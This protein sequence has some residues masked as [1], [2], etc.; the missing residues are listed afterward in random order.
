MLAANRNIAAFGDPV[1]QLWQHDWDE[2]TFRLLTKGLLE[3]DQLTAAGRQLRVQLETM[4]DSLAGE[5]PV[6]ALGER[7]T[8]DLVDEL[9][10][11]SFDD[12][13]RRGYSSANRQCAVR[14]GRGQRRQGRQLLDGDAVV[15]RWRPAGTAVCSVNT[16][17]ATCAESSAGT[18]LACQ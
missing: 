7:G 9:R 2:A 8:E 13:R 3:G 12:T 6:N 18:S 16:S 10:A 17:P 15:A 5:P 11:M 4:T 14:D 1:A